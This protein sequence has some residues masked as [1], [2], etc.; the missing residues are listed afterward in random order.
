[1]AG[2]ISSFP[3]GVQSHASE[4]GVGVLSTNSRARTTRGFIGVVT[5][6]VSFTSA[7]GLWFMPNSRV[8]VN[9]TPTIGASSV[10]VSTSTV[11]PSSGTMT[12]IE[13][14]ERVDAM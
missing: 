12:V 9:N 10:G 6:M 2:K 13:G 11:D 1:M 5:D 7:T 4:R 3:M 8:R 14:D